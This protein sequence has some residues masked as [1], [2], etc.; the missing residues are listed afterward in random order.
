MRNTFGNNKALPR[1]KIDNAILEIDQKMSVQNEK[2][3]INIL[4]FVPVIFALHHGHPDDGVIH[5]AK[6]LVIPFVGAGIGQLLHI[7]ELKRSA[8]KVQVRFV[9]KSLRGLIGVHDWN[10][11]T[12]Q[13]TGNSVSFGVRRRIPVVCHSQR[14]RGISGFIF[15]RQS[16]ERCLDFARH[17][18]RSFF[19]VEVIRFPAFDNDAVSR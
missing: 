19:A 14:S 5:F 1:S 17:H 4:V 16:I 13:V 18:N 8:Q 2:E 10:L 3:F 11:D 15:A 9:R 6:R 7:D 12:E